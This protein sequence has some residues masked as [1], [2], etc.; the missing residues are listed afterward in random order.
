MMMS[1]AAFRRFTTITL[2]ALFDCPP[3]A[4]SMLSLMFRRFFAIDY[5]SPSFD[6]AFRLPPLLTGFFFYVILFSRFSP[7]WP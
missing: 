2:F 5:V 3:Y 7:S 6:A 1:A 4:I